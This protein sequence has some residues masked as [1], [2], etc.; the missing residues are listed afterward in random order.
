MALFNKGYFKLHSGRTDFFKIDCDFLGDLDLEAVT[1]ELVVR[2][3]PFGSVEG[4]GRGGHALADAFRKHYPRDLFSLRSFPPLICDDVLTT[5]RS[6]EEQR[7]GR[8]AIGAVIF[9]RGPVPAWVQPLFYMAGR[10]G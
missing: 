6:M 1:Q 9:A 10:P 8:Q 2:L 7:R 5:G 3:R 4:V